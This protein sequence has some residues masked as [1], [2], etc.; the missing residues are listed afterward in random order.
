MILDTLT[1]VILSPLLLIQAIGVRKAALRLPEAT[2]PRN[3]TCGSGPPLRVLI[4]GDSS[5]AGVGA[6]TQDAAL[7][8]QLAAALSSHHTVHWH[9]IASTGATTPTTLARLQAETL[10]AADIAIV[11]LG[12]N[13]VTRGGPM[14]RWLRTHSLLRAVLRDR[15]GAQRLYISQVPPLGAFPLLP[16]PLRWLLGRRA[17]RFDMAL[18]TALGHEP[19]TR[20]VLLP[21]ML[22]VTDMAEDSFHPGP[23]IYAAWAK[24][25]ARQILSD[26]PV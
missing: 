24:E 5:A 7:A 14:P 1:T 22:D 18:R 11:I 23:V 8:G 10:P 9:L 15:T 2:G 20:Y 13:D 6:P 25:M 19:D 4:V 16:N 3:A 26:G 17:V 12:V 21:D